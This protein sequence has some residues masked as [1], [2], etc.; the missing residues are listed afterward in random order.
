MSEISCVWR[1][2]DVARPQGPPV[3]CTGTSKIQTFNYR[4]G[5]EITIGTVMG[6]PMFERAAAA[7]LRAEPTVTPTREPIRAMACKESS[8]ITVL[9]FSVQL[10]M[11]EL[12]SIEAQMQGHFSEHFPICLVPY[13]LRTLP[14]WHPTLLPSS[15]NKLS[16]NT[17][18]SNRLFTQRWAVNI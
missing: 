7:L 18:P 9:R 14:S 1:P 12:T 6:G 17:F 2:C 16:G 5:S 10:T 13:I 3:F 4:G 8:G 15:S 11:Q